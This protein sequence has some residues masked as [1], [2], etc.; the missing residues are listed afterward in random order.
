M[1]KNPELE[2]KESIETSALFQNIDK[3]LM[4]FFVKSEKR[5]SNP[6]ANLDSYEKVTLLKAELKK[7]IEEKKLSPEW[8]VRLDWDIFIVSIWW[9]NFE[10]DTKKTGADWDS[11]FVW[12]KKEKEKAFLEK[13]KLM[14]QAS[15]YLFLMDRIFY[16]NSK[17]WFK[18]LNDEDSLSSKEIDEY[19]WYWYNIEW[20]KKYNSD[21]VDLKLI[22]KEFYLVYMDLQKIDRSK[23]DE[24]QKLRLAT[25]EE[26]YLDILMWVWDIYEGSVNILSKSPEEVTELLNTLLSNYSLEQTLDYFSNLMSKI[27]S[28]KHIN[29]KVWESYKM[30]KEVLQKEIFFKMRKDNATTKD[31]VRFVKMLR[32]DWIYEMQDDL[33]SVENDF[34]WVLSWKFRWKNS[35][36]NEVIIYAMG[37]K[38]WIIDKVKSN[39]RLNLVDEKIKDKKPSEIVNNLSEKLTKTRGFQNF[40]F[41]SDIYKKVLELWETKYEDLTNVQ[42]TALS[43]LFRLNEKLETNSDKIKTIDDLRNTFKEISD[44]FYLESV[45]QFEK[46]I[47]WGWNPF[48]WD[49]YYWKVW[50][51]LWLTWDEN[52]LFE[53]FKD[54]NW[55]G[56]LD[57][58]DLASENFKAIWKFWVIMWAAIL[59]PEIFV[60]KAGIVVQSAVAWFVWDATYQ[61]MSN[62]WYL[63][64]K[65]AIANIL[66][67]SAVA[68]VSAWLAWKVLYWSWWLVS[69][70]FNKLLP[71]NRMK[72]AFLQPIDLAIFWIIP[73]TFRSQQIEKIFNSESVFDEGVKAKIK[74]EKKL[75][76]TN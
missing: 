65:E 62:K 38:W 41:S 47:E 76:K 53:Q 49:F 46:L 25:I 50:D 51:K 10:F 37:Q 67:E 54:F 55:V 31:F 40:V 14:K 56:I 57:F 29:T 16:K 48:K 58:S 74:A 43:I 5:L 52:E 15:D 12:E 61:L 18:E 39:D 64:K 1:W 19:I 20:L 34:A 63:T 11:M 17:E 6:R 23:L 21:K 42:K 26:K 59:A 70:T 33:K 8:T 45:K 36:V 66:T 68:T 73:E 71:K 44:E 60:P 27:N 2:K 35:F 22:Q 4:D 72:Q 3:L 7:I 13:D 30:M 24:R 28:N 9:N 32:W 69:E 75:E